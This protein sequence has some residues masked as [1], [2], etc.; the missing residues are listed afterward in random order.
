[1]L[2]GL[3]YYGNKASFKDPARYPHLFEEIVEPTNREKWKRILQSFYRRRIH[4]DNYYDNEGNTQMSIEE[5]ISDDLISLFDKNGYD[6]D[7]IYQE[8][9][10]NKNK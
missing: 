9:I 2:P 6:A 4:P 3:R 8:I 7:K 10:I 1:M 5:F